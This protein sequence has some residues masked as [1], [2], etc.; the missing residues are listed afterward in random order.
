ML[1]VA[2]DGL[3]GADLGDVWPRVVGAMIHPAVA[4]AARLV[5]AATGL[6]L[7]PLPEPPRPVA[8]R[9]VEAG[10]EAMLDAAR[11]GWVDDEPPTRPGPFGPLR[12]RTPRAKAP[13]TVHEGG[14]REPGASLPPEPAASWFTDD[15]GPHSAGPRT[16]PPRP[17]RA[18]SSS[19]GGEEGGLGAGGLG[20]GGFGAGEPAARSATAPG[21]RATSGAA[22]RASQ[23]VSAADLLATHGPTGALLRAVRE[24]RGLSLQAVHESTRI[25]MPT[26][27]AIEAEDFDALPSGAVFVR[28]YVRDIART[29]GLDEQLVV[30]GYM[31]RFHLDG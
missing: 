9:R 26:L 10:V 13:L 2:G 17:A 14:A 3:V 16:S 6:H 21:V 8:G 23:G 15:D 22:S 7:G 24:L 29:L 19:V 11:E 30:E 20:A 1:A 31:R 12:Q 28:G 27:A 4:A 25:S 18:S 5:D